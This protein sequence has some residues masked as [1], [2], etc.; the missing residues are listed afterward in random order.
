[1]LFVGQHKQKTGLCPKDL[2]A[3]KD[4]L[5]KYFEEPKEENIEKNR[6]N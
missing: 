5:N 1:M 6:I 2:T 4:H 3:L